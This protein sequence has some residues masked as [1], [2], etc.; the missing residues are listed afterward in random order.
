[1][2]KISKK[3]SLDPKAV[4]RGERFSRLH[5]TSLSRLVNDFLA[6]LP[7]DDV[8]PDL[9]PTVRRLLGVAKGGPDENDYREY[10]FQ[11]YGL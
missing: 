5:S 11:K 8:E 1:M 9:T 4:E 10:L 2:A 7:V 3:L 6:Q